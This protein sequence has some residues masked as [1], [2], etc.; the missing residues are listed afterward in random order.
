VIYV[1]KGAGNVRSGDYDILKKV[2]NE[3][4]VT[5]RV[6]LPGGRIPP[7]KIY[8]VPGHEIPALNMQPQTAKYKAMMTLLLAENVFKVK[9]SD[10]VKFIE[11]M[12]KASW[13]NEFLPRR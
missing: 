3:G 4:V 5:F 2:E 13:A 8:D 10:K 1:S 9:K 11:K 12:M 7:Q 6:P